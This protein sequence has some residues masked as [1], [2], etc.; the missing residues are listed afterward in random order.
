[1]DYFKK[2]KLQV[3]IRDHSFLKHDDDSPRSS[4]YLTMYFRFLYNYYYSIIIFPYLVLQASYRLLN[5][6]KPEQKHCLQKYDSN[7]LGPMWSHSI[8][9]KG[10]LGTTLLFFSV[11]ILSNLIHFLRAIYNTIYFKG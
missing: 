6:V 5:N 2:K 9:V 1:M 4:S 8:P 10:G 7:I 3:E 11:L